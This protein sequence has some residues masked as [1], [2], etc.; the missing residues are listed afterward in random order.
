MK[1]YLFV[2][3]VC[4]FFTPSV[5]ALPLLSNTA[6]LQ[7]KDNTA[8]VQTLQQILN[9]DPDTQ[10]ATDGAGSP[11]HE[12]W[13]F[14]ALTENAVERFQQKYDLNVTGKVDYKTRVQLNSI[15]A[16]GPTDSAQTQTNTQVDNTNTQTNSQKKIST[17]TNTQTDNSENQNNSQTD[18]QNSFLGD[19]T[20]Q[21]IS[22]S[23]SSNNSQDNSST[24]TSYAQNLINSI[25]GKYSSLFGL[26]NVLPSSNTTQPTQDIYSNSYS[27]KTPYCN[28]QTGIC[29]S[30]A[31]YVQNSQTQA[32]AQSQNPFLPS[33]GNPY[34]SQSGASSLGSSPFG[35]P[36]SP[37]SSF[38]SGLSQALGIQTGPAQA[39]SENSAGKTSGLAGDIG[40]CNASTFA[41]ATLAE[42]CS[43]DR[44]DQ[45]NGARSASGVFLSKEGLPAIPAV[46]LPNRGSFGDAV[47]VKVMSTGQCKAFPLLDRGPS[48]AIVARG[49]CID[50]TGSAVDI[51][52]GKTPCKTVTSKSGK[53]GNT[54][55]GKIQ[56]AIVPGEKIQP[57]Q[58]K[59]CSHLK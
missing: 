37:Q 41:H 11:G 26:N 19:T 6:Y 25:L 47:E 40:F 27:A 38:L 30:N 4:T 59:E 2:S 9:S 17:N 57:G 5:F 35:A 44:E 31:N 21:Y 1:K 10:V 22:S 46:A 50:I 13:Y 16:N 42:G 45:Q 49:K 52:Q 12:L 54:E 56:Y 36:S 55:V 23:D 18:S 28:S 58:T 39:G 48:A 51:L 7:Y 43:A 3:L 29:S 8:E 24:T 34:T 53:Q 20:N 32:A 33:T 15:A 14:G